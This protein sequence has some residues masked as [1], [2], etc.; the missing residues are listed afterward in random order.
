MGL[1]RVALTLGL[2]WCTPSSVVVVVDVANSKSR[3]VTCDKGLP[4]RIDQ[5][6]QIL[7]KR[8]LCCVQNIFQVTNTTF[9]ERNS[10][11]DVKSHARVRKGNCEIVD[12]RTYMLCIEKLSTTNLTL[13]TSSPRLRDWTR[14]SG[15][16]ERSNKAIWSIC[17]ILFPAIKVS[18]NASSIAEVIPVGSAGQATRSKLILH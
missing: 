1:Y 13:S 2:R 8:C 11:H 17:R 14:S 16:I 18:K 6:F 9:V 15:R 5:N 10:T 7:I 12:G 3:R 4:T